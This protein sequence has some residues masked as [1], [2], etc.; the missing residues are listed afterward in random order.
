MSAPGA[1]DALARFDP[2]D[3]KSAADYGKQIASDISEDARWGRIAWG[4]IRTAFAHAIDDLEREGLIPGEAPELRVV[5]GMAELRSRLEKI[6]SDH[7]ARTQE[8]DLSDEMRAIRAGAVNGLW[9]AIE[10]LDVIGASRARLAH[11]RSSES[12]SARFNAALKLQGVNLGPDVTEAVLRALAAMDE[13]P[14]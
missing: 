13:V 4:D 1:H 6:K 10:A 14:Q 11:S 2:H 5:G 9:D 7:E 8:P 12:A 3:Q